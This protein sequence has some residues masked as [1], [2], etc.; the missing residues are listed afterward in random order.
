MDI[1]RVLQSGQPLPDWGT[2]TSRSIPTTSRCS[3]ST[4]WGRCRRAFSLAPDAVLI[5]LNGICVGVTLYAVHLLVVRVAGRGPALAAQ[6]ATLVLVGTSPW[7]A[8]PY[9]DFY[10]MPFVV[11][12]VALAVR[13][14]TPRART[15]RVVLWLLAIVSVSVAYSIKTTPVVIAI[16][17]VLTAVVAIFDHHDLPPARRAGVIAACAASALAFVALGVGL[18]P[19]DRCLRGGLLAHRHV[20]LAADH[21]VGRFGGRRAARGGRSGQLRR[22]L[23]RDG[24]CRDRPAR[25][26]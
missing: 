3:P 21:L 8:V 12:G 13:A 16:A 18:T 7:L 4:E 1:A 10:A 19:R 24:R 5:P 6:L 2:T 17:A 25:T 26:R 23:P 9:T 15:G 14:M 20:G 22:V 11:G